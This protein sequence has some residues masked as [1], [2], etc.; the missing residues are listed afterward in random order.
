MPSMC[1]SLLSERTHFKAWLSINFFI[2]CH[3][4]STT[5]TK[6]CFHVYASKMKLPK[7]WNNTP[8]MDNVLKHSGSDT[9]DYLVYYVN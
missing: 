2:I 9:N 8:K 3:C 4:E 6:P 7:L 1:A 5:C